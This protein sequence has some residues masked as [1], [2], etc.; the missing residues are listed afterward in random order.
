MLMTGHAACDFDEHVDVQGTTYT[1]VHLKDAP[2]DS[3]P[4]TAALLLGG[5]LTLM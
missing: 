3:F 1:N 5:L 4:G 2:A